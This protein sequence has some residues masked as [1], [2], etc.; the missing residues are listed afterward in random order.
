MLLNSSRIGR[1][2]LDGSFGEWEWRKIGRKTRCPSFPFLD[3]MQRC[4]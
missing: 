2:R 1:E 4:R 3:L